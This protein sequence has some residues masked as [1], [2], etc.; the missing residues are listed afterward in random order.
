M[1]ELGALAVDSGAV[2]AYPAPGV[3]LIGAA[4]DEHPEY[5]GRFASVWE[6]GGRR[7]FLFAAEDSGFRF[8]AI[9]AYSGSA[10]RP[11]SWY[12]LLPLG[13]ENRSS[14]AFFGGAALL[15]PCDAKTGVSPDSLPGGVIGNTPGF[16]PGI[17]GSSPGRVGLSEERRP[18][19]VDGG[20]HSGGG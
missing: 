12:V 13:F 11:F 18:R 10:P 19:G 8:G 1:G 14:R 6:P 9:L 3:G 16:G 2:P 5:K 17:P 15:I 4:L 7:V 20:D